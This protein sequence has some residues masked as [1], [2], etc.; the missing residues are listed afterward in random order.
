MPRLL[1]T[2]QRCGAPADQLSGEPKSW[3]DLGKHLLFGVADALAA[4]TQKSPS[5]AALIPMSAAGLI[6]VRFSA[7]KSAP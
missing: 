7:L 5:V 3:R 4:K 1:Q 2:R 6:A